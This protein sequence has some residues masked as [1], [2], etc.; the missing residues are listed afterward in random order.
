M[1]SDGEDVPSDVALL[2][3]ALSNS[4]HSVVLASRGTRQSGIWFELLYKFFN[5][6][7]RLLTGQKL[8]TGNF[9]AVKHSWLSTLIELPSIENHISAAIVRYCP[10]F[11]TL[12]LN[13]GK[14][15][16]GKSRMNIASLSLHGYGALSVYADVALS[17]LVVGV[18]V[19]GLTLGSFAALL[20]SLK[21][22]SSSNFF[23]GWTSNVV[24]QLFSLSVITVL[25]AV[26]TTLVILWS[27]GRAV[28]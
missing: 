6:P 21:L 14:R 28:K 7:F 3:N 5:L 17:R 10:D 18:S 12:R 19:F 22:F 27:K 4:T 15:Y 26:T 2:L 11:S 1:D 8:H 9:M 24:L 16:F 25:Q 13:R 20:V 23:P